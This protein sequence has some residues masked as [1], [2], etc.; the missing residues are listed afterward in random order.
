LD[1]RIANIKS[2]R[3][4]AKT[5]GAIASFEK[6]AKRKQMVIQSIPELISHNMFRD[7]L[8]KLAKAYWSPD[9]ISALVTAVSQFPWDSVSSQRFE[10]SIYDLA[11]LI[12]VEDAKTY[13]APVL[14]QITA[15]SV[16]TNIAPVLSEIRAK[17]A[18]H[19][20]SLWHDNALLA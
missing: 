10:K 4:K 14:N 18:K 11:P 2:A 13:I 17:R 5:L 16:K 12:S 20:L 9:F 6:T 1:D 3:Q 15:V 7:D 8:F 19:I